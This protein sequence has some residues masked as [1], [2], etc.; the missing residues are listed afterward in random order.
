MGLGQTLEN[1]VRIG[2]APVLHLVDR[3]IL[4]QST[5]QSYILKSD[6]RDDSR[7]SYER[8]PSI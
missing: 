8:N 2:T 7:V 6:H 1:T 5:I 4:D 3:D